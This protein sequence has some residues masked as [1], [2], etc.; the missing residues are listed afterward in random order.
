MKK[1]YLL[2]ICFL[3]F[4][5][6]SQATHI[7]GG[8]IQ[9]KHLNGY[10]YE[11]ILN[12]YFDAING[13]AEAEDPSATLTFYSKLG[14]QLM[15]RITLPKVSDENVNYTNPNCSN[16]TLKTRLLTY[17][18]AL[19]LS[20]NV[21]NSPAGYYVIWERC[22]RNGTI[23]NIQN[24]GAAGMTFYTE[25]PPVMRNNSQFINSSPAFTIPKGDYL[26]LDKPFT[27]D[28]G[29]TDADG[30]ELV[31]SF[32]TPLNGNSRPEPQDLITPPPF[33][34]PYS[35]VVWKTGFNATNAIASDAT[36]PSHKIQIDSQN[37]QITVTPN[38]QGLFVF[39]VRCEEYRNG[40][41]IGEVRRD[42]QLLVIDCPEN[43]SPEIQVQ[44]GT[45]NGSPVFYESGQVLT[46]N[47]L[48]NELCFDVYVKDNDE[49][50]ER[51]STSIRGIN[52]IASQSFLSPTSAN[53][54]GEDSL[55]IKFCWSRCLF[56]SKNNQGDLIPFE[57]DLIVDDNGCP[58]S[59]ADTIRVKLISL[60]VD[61]N[62][63]LISANANTSNTQGID[64]EE[65]LIVNGTFNFTVFGED[66]ID[67]D[68]ITITAVG[69]GFNLNDL[70]MQFNSATGIGTVQSPFLWETDCRFVKQDITEY[71]IDFYVKDKG[72]CEDK[73]DTI[74][75]KL[76][77]KDT[78]IDLT[79]LPANVFTP[80]GDLKNEVFKI[81][82]LPEENCLY[83]FEKITIYNRWGGKVFESDSRDFEWDGGG[84]PTGE[85]FYQID[86]KSKI[87]K[88]WVSLL[89]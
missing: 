17:K 35:L 87:Y 83:Q 32:Q 89:K 49:L 2:L 65:E 63:P 29:A 72:F 60:P 25:I 12:L 9:V 31:Y 82:D 66:L 30:D 33:P 67:N 46:V 52:F 37:G 3:L 80:N 86:Y 43:E 36:E 61:D 21:Y 73:T 19:T 88:G 27:F 62:A 75:V 24:P 34:A 79:F 15:T 48:T 18:A 64:Y 71:I 5:F 77:I 56:S 41:K 81:P 55:K 4:A 53:I 16:S 51:V 74:T 54:V 6:Q 10:N 59:N 38:Q 23:D 13:N 45:N 7:V 11:V 85:Y 70:G 44:S 50:N 22:C 14:N 26:C 76:I 1:N 57:F 39:S 78:P 40:I 42:Y 47:A 8:E 28:F 68:E 84:L 69:R 58:A 20:P